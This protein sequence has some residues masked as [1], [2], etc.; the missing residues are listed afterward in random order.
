MSTKEQGGLEVLD[1]G[2]LS[3]LNGWWSL[4]RIRKVFGMYFLI[5]YL[6]LFGVS[7]F[8]WS[9]IFVGIIPVKLANFHKQT[10]LAWNLIHKHNLSPHSYFIWNNQDIL[11]KNKLLFYYTWFNEWIVLVR[12]F[13]NSN[14]YLFS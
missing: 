6:K 14:E 4:W 7:T 13:I 11:F 9:A 2:A 3:K 12:Q 5:I 10:L 8:C 1:F